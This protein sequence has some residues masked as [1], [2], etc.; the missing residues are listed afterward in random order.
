MNVGI[1]FGSEIIGPAESHGVP[2]NQ[3]TGYTEF[4]IGIGRGSSNQLENGANLLHGQ[5]FSLSLK[6]ISIE[7]CVIYFRQTLVVVTP[8]DTP[9]AQK[10]LSII[11]AYF[12]KKWA[13][14][15]I[16]ATQYYN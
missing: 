6:I 4:I 3:L 15:H 2:G 16:N 1:G 5:V 8:D 9:L 12:A 7:F 14:V 11:Q 13:C 10:D